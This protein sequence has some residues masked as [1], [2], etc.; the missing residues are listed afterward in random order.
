MTLRR[1]MRIGAREFRGGGRIKMTAGPHCLKRQESTMQPTTPLRTSIL[2]ACS[3][4]AAS[5]ALA[6]SVDVRFIDPASY[7]LQGSTRA[8]EDITLQALAQHLQQLGARYLPADQTLKV[9]V[10][11][12][13]LA[14]N[15]RLSHT[16]VPIRV[17]RGNADFPQIKLKYTLEANGRPL[18]S[19]EEW[20]KD[21]DYARGYQSTRATEP[22]HYEKR[23]LDVWFK[24]RFAPAG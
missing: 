15:V 24:E 4:F 22:L 18:R 6:G 14:G 2:L 8:D 20:V 16:G 12:V 3:V 11:D 19:G 21:I 5:S 17:V 1:T 9:E 13:V 10:Q 23:M 7:G